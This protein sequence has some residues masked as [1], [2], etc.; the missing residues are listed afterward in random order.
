MSYQKSKRIRK[1]SHSSFII[2]N[3]QFLMPLL[4]LS[5]TLY[6]QI[7]QHSVTITIDLSAPTAQKVTAALLGVNNP[8]T[9]LPSRAGFDIITGAF[10]PAFMGNMEILGLRS[11]RFP[12]G[13]NSG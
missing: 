10:P 13:N 7:S 1:D 12:G 4:L 11:L 8:M 9:D 2:F 5:T 3:S 6:P